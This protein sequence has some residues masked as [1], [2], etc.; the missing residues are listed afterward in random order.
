MRFIT[1]LL[2]LVLL[3][4]AATAQAEERGGRLREF[5]QQ[6]QSGG[7]EKLF[8]EDRLARGKMS[9]AQKVEQMKSKKF[10]SRIGK[11]G[12]PEPD[13]TVSYGKHDLQAYDVY[14]PKNPVH[15][16]PFPVIM[17]VH[18]GGWCVGDKGMGRMVA[19]KIKRWV[20][21][22]FIFVSVNYR[23]VADGVFPVEQAED[24][25]DALAS[26]QNNASK[27]Q[28]DPSRIIIMGHSA[29]AHLVSLITANS[30]KTAA[31]GVQPWLGTISLD[32]AAMD[33][34][35]M[36]QGTPANLY[37]EAFGADENYWR[38]AS[39]AHQVSKDSRPW[40]GVCSSKRKAKVCADS[41]AYAEK[42]RQLG[43]RAESLPIAFGHGK[44]NSELGAPGDY[45]DAVEKFMS[46]LDA[47]VA[48]RLK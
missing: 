25:A 40:L 33:I 47:E 48:E 35:A 26:L 15:A 1:A 42:S 16:A 5:L 2:V 31:R 41:E 12:V 34:V 23:M 45:T 32:T 3:S 27:W 28:G 6:R 19:N 36:M 7:G 11:D 17:M 8:D 10:I 38:E 13:A 44:I 4:L 29:G 18:G 22:G 46:S 43:L 24:V 14:I 37:K 9:C 20:E 39:P 21:K 30:T